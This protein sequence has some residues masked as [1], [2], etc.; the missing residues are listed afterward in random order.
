[1]EK[2]RT[3]SNMKQQLE[4]PPACCIRE[5]HLL[6]S[7]YGPAGKGILMTGYSKQIKGI[8]GMSEV[9]RVV[10]R[11]TWSHLPLSAS[12]SNRH[13]VLAHLKPKCLLDTARE[14]GSRLQEVKVSSP[15]N[16]LYEEGVTQFCL[17]GVINSPT[18]ALHL[19]VVIISETRAGYQS[20][21]I[22][23]SK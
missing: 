16:F 22:G 2:V 17:R 6:W 4:H 9:H 20:V 5:P 12:K 8:Y 19:K 1:M 18:R 3:V 14:R 15:D 23:H 7:A 11:R 13:A 21:Y 10:Q